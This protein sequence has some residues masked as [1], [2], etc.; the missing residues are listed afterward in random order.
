MLSRSAMVACC[1]LV[2]LG[3]HAAEDADQAKM[4]QSMLEG[5]G[6]KQTTDI[7]GGNCKIVVDA[8]QNKVIDSVPLLQKFGILND[9]MSKSELT[10]TPTKTTMVIALQFAPVEIK[11]IYDSFPDADKCSFTH[12]IISND[13]Y[14]NSRKETMFTYG[15]DRATY[16]KVNWDNF[17][18]QNLIKI[19]RGFAFNPAIARRTSEE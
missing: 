17:K 4:M 2:P 12:N 14:G 13:E 1:L 9:E 16:S 6:F 11:G 5:M 15:F 3:C 19:G 18:S 8:T 10:R 7:K